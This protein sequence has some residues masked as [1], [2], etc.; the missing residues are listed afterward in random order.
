MIDIHCHLLY[1]VDDGAATLD[2][3]V[4]MLREAAGQGITDIIL[5]PHYRKGMFP[6]DLSKI[7]EAY[8]TLQPVA[9]ESGIRL[10]L[11]CEYHANS[12][13]VE[14]LRSGRVI[15]MAGTDYVL[16]EYSE[17]DTM[18]RIQNSLDDLLSNG[19][20]PIIA[21]AERYGAVAKDPEILAQF[22]Q[23]G[24]LVQI[25]A[26]SILGYDGHN[27]KRICKKI[28]K[29]DLADIVASDSHDMHD[30]KCLMGECMKYVEK[31]YDHLRAVR[32]FVK[33]PGRITEGTLT[34][35]E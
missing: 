20:I 13:M 24:A 33:N 10:Y 14:N 29:N 3:S 4:A 32:L 22:R 8:E 26:G 11:G 34:T 5:T 9:E 7:T 27:L 16:A 21:H 17:E 23:M 15:T 31:K 2:M 25:N 1:G 28:L 12:D 19:Y 35:I 18:L 30:R 6:F